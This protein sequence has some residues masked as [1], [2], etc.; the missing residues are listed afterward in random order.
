[1]I[2]KELIKEFLL[3][4]ALDLRGLQ[5]DGPLDRPSIRSLLLDTQLNSLSVVVH[6]SNE[7]TGESVEMDHV[8]KE[9]KQLSDPALLRLSEAMNDEARSAYARLVLFSCLEKERNNS[10][11]HVQ[12]SRDILRKEVLDYCSLCSS[13]LQLDSV[14]E[15]VQKGSP[16]FQQFSSSI[17]STPA[18]R[19]Q[20]IQALIFQDLGYN[21]SHGHSE[22]K[23]LFFSEASEYVD[24]EKVVEAVGRMLSAVSQ[25]IANATINTRLSDTDKGGVTRV[26]AT[27]HSEYTLDPR[28]GQAQLAGGAPPKQRIQEQVD[29]SQFKEENRMQVA[30]SSLQQDIQREFDSLTTSER[31]AKVQEAHATTIKVM[32]QAASLPPGPARIQFLQSIDENTQRLMIINKL[33]S[34]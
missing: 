18:K 3:K 22:M 26:V 24:D 4:S 34:S 1:M 5:I 11:G 9:L 6:E 29:E 28:T 27:S 30:V 8:Q 14:A 33:A 12:T 16:L 19:V 13:I 7:K 2:Q 25:T 17:D 21:P 10:Y 20:A 32:Q 31:E 15:H 23:R